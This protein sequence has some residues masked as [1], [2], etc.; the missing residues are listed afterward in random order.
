M[1][2]FRGDR[3]FGI[4]GATRVLAAYLG[5][6]RNWELKCCNEGLFPSHTCQGRKESS[7]VW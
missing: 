2:L 5:V 7:R 6:R 3:L 4:M 1:L